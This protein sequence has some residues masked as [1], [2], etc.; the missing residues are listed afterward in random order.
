MIGL[1]SALRAPAVRSSL[2][3][4]LRFLSP[5]DITIRHHWVGQRRLRLDAFRHR[6]YWSRGKKREHDVMVSLPKILRPGQTVI[7][8]GGHIGYLTI[9]FASLVSDGGKVVVF[10]PAPANLD[11]LRRNVEGLPQVTVEVAAASDRAGSA[12]F[13][14][15]NLTG[16]N[17]SLLGGYGQFDRVR[18]GLSIDASYE[19]ISVPTIRVDDYVEEHGLRPDFVKIDIEGA[20]ELALKGM[21][22]TL[23]RFRPAM[24]IETTVNVQE[25]LA[26]LDGQGYREFNAALQPADRGAETSHNFFLHREAHKGL[27][28]SLEGEAVPASRT[29]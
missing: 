12:D 25:V 29:A 27:I 6:N 14:V 21:Q 17:N 1:D 19:K 4:L 9:Y 26:M 2:L 23:G 5:G 3:S 22:R 13:F 24:L 18:K 8:L 20:E 16:Q 28:A 15:E 7:E 10:E 11:Y